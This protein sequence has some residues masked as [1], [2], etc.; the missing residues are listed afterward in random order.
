MT[1]PLTDSEHLAANLALATHELREA[2]ERIRRIERAEA[3]AHRSKVWAAF[4]AAED[5]HR[6]YE[7]R[8]AST[9]AEFVGAVL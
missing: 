1:R 9:L 4:Q 3:V 2:A 6:A 5:L 8:Y 7:E